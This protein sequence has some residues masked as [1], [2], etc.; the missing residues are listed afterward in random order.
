[1]RISEFLLSSSIT[2][3]ALPS[4][5]W[6]N[7]GVCF[8]KFMSMIAMCFSA[9]DSARGIVFSRMFFI[10][11]FFKMFRITASFVFAKMMDNVFS[12]NRLNKIFIGKL[13]SCIEFIISV[14][15]GI[16]CSCVN[17]AFPFPTSRRSN[18]AMSKKSIN[19][20]KWFSAHNYPFVIN[21]IYGH[22]NIVK[23]ICKGV[24]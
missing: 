8:G 21:Y 9:I 16:S 6:R 3:S 22:Y 20:V 4:S 19:R 10:C 17:F 5:V 15:V 12:A 13:V 23:N 7:I 11:N 1:M 2:Y 18:N 24:S 14:K